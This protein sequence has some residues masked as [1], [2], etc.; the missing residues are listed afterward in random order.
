MSSRGAGSSGQGSS[1]HLS[2]SDRRVAKVDALYNEVINKVIEGL[3]PDVRA[4]GLDASMNEGAPLY[5]LKTT[6][7][8]KLY[9]TGCLDQSSASAVLANAI[10]EG[11][12]LVASQY[13]DPA[14]PEAADGGDYK[15]QQPAKRS[16]VAGASSS[17]MPRGSEQYSTLHDGEPDETYR[18]R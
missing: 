2:A 3:K 16:R 11:R 17:G 6:W 15:N 18:P 14:V 5:I 12:A 7:L 9:A 13:V 4:A 1:S 10:G 8:E